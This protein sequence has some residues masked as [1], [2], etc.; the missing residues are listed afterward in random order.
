MSDSIPVA[1]RKRE[2]LAQIRRSVR[3]TAPRPGERIGKIEALCKEFR[4]LEALEARSAKQG[5]NRQEKAGLDRG[6]A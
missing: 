4:E 2:I 6:E 5:R 1:T 3:I